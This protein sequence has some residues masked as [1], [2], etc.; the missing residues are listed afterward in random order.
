MNFST[1]K[2]SELLGGNVSGEN[3]I[4]S[5]KDYLCN[6]FVYKII[7]GDR[8]EII[9]RERVTIFGDDNYKSRVEGRIYSALLPWFLNSNDQF[10]TENFKEFKE[11]FNTPTIQPRDLSFG[12]LWNTILSSYI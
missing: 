4:K 3:G 11:E 8:S 7:E 9:E 2:E 12:K 5:N 1:I 6:N 10:R